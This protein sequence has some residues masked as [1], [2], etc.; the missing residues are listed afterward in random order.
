MEGEAGTDVRAGFCGNHPDSFVAVPLVIKG[1]ARGA[2]YVDN[3]VREHSITDEDIQ[4]LTMFA[5]KACLAMENAS[6]Y[7]S[8][9]RALDDVRATQDRLVQSEKLMALGASASKS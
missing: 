7:E 4:V 5:S 9:E 8:L 6:L 3:Q 1:E 2:I